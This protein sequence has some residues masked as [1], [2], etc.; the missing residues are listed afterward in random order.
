[1]PD[2]LVKLYDL[3]DRSEWLLP[4]NIKIRK[5][6]AAEMS[7]V[8]DWVRKYFNERWR[9]EVLVSFS[10][11]PCSCFIAAIGKDIAGF[12][13]YDSSGLGLFGPTG[14]RPNL[15]GKGIGKALLLSCLED[16][17]AKGYAYAVIGAVGPSRFYEKVA[18]AV[19]IPGSDASIFRRMIG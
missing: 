1:M 8:G 7:F 15:R 2:M 10:R 14:V 12:A 16:M 6:I 19:L 11:V 17:R 13:C 5:P 9:S 3:P 18:G 4:D